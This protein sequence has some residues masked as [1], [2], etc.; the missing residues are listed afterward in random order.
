MARYAE[1]REQI[2][3][4]GEDF[5]ALGLSSGQVGRQPANDDL[6]GFLVVN[7][8]DADHTWIIESIGIRAKVA[9]EEK[10]ATIIL[11]D[12]CV[13]SLALEVIGI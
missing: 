9:F 3:L 1:L 5:V 11:N 13:A 4:Q 12:V 2:H 6:P 7:V 8:I 10:A